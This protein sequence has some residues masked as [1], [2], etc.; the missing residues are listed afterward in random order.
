MPHADVSWHHYVSSNCFIVIF[1][2]ETWIFVYNLKTKQQQ[3]VKL[4]NVDN[5]KETKTIKS[6]SCWWHSSMWG[7]LSIVSSYQR[8]WQSISKSTRCILWSVH[9]KRQEFW[10]DEL[11][12]LHHDSEPAHNTLNIQQ[13]LTKTVGQIDLF[14]NYEYWIA[15]LKTIELCKNSSYE[16]RIFY[17]ISV[18]KKKW[19]NSR[20][21]D[22]PLKLINPI[23]I[24][25][26]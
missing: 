12:L 5:A 9:K 22:R 16:R 7:T 14:E 25:W 19:N 10:Q 23:L 15:I 8:A 20:R 26:T 21:V 11:W 6:Q 2:D 13:F 1:G 17:I 4:S 18:F 24:Y 3:P